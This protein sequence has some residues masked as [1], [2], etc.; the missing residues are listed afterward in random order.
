[1]DNEVVNDVFLKPGY[2]FEL[3][4]GLFYNI[5][6]EDRRRLYIL[7]SI[8]GYFMVLIYNDKYYFGEA[9]IFRDLESLNIY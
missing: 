7:Y 5:D 1:M 6:R 9:R 8:M 3:R 4:G 2:P